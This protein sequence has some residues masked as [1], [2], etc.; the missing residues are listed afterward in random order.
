MKVLIVGDLH[1]QSYRLGFTHRRP[2]F[3]IQIFKDLEDIREETGIKHLVINGDL[4]NSKY[5]LDEGALKAWSDIWLNHHFE[6]VY[7]NC[8]DHD[9]LKRFILKWFSDYPTDYPVV[10]DP[11]TVGRDIVIVPYGPNMKQQIDFC[12]TLDPKP[13]Y[14]ITHCTLKEMQV[15]S[16][17]SLDGSISVK[18]LHPERFNLVVVSGHYKSQS[19]EN[20]ICIDP[21]L[22]IDPASPVSPGAWVLDTKGDKLYPIKFPSLSSRFKQHFVTGNVFEPLPM[23]NPEDFNRIYA[24]EKILKEYYQSY[25]KAEVVPA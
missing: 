25:P 22:Q 10:D 13:K 7:Y 4:W 20:V 19:L 15:S 5:N 3:G 1:L 12:K 6:T 2:E 18:D 16:G 23:Y 11:M 24:P 17:Q 14:L 21:P 9:Y 8:G